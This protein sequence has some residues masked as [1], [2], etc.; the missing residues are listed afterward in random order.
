MHAVTRHCGAPPRYHSRQGPALVG[1]HNLYAPDAAGDLPSPRALLEVSYILSLHRRGT[2]AWCIHPRPVSEAG[3][4]NPYD[5]LKRPLILILL[6]S[7]INS[8][9]REGDYNA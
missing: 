1:S 3:T 2:L 5:K 6:S 9:E 4:L 7:Q 8:Q